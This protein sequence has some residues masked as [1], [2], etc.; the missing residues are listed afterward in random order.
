MDPYDILIVGGGIAG[1]YCA[2]ELLKARPSLRLVLCE[3]YKIL[4]G[5]M[6]T[7]HKTLPG[8]LAVQW[9]IGAGRI[10]DSHVHLHALLREYGLH[11]FPISG[12]L[13]YKESGSSELE[14]N[15][16][17]PSLDILFGPLLGLPT[18]VLGRHTL[19]QLLISIHGKK[20]TQEWM[21]RFP[22]HSEFVYLR[23]DE[24]LREFRN[25]MKSHEGFSVC[26]EGLGTL[27]EKMAAE[28]VERGAVIL[29][30]YTCTDLGKGWAEFTSEGLSRK[31][32]AK[33]IICALHAKAMGSLPFFN[34]F[35]TLKKIQM[36]PLTR[37]YAVFPL[38]GGKVW[39]SGLPRIVTPLSIRYVLPI[40][41][42]K[43]VIMISYTDS[44]FSR[45]FSEKKDPEAE[46]MKEIRA[47]FPEKDIP[48]PLFFKVHEWKEG[49]SYWL[50]GGY[51]VKEE[52]ERALVPF[53]KAY[54]GLYVCGESFSERQGWVE[55][56]IEHAALLL[57]KKFHIG[58]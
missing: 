6:A 29:T 14:K 2:R 50:P 26:A 42:A 45:A 28:C 43:G 32:H 30:H 8:D 39:F 58:K 16:F 19:Q 44:K 57:K 11:T 54:P 46:V 18:E 38:R 3:Q 20:A 27:A 24:G 5:R 51:T 34:G 17:E 25:E 23:A 33:K 48:D 36:E 55:G 1:L 47:L 13:L 10:S 21:D 40:D 52:S 12:D 49:V 4:G 7:Y 22:Y 56:A 41:E 37:M 35:S 9:E 53:P 31:I 15:I